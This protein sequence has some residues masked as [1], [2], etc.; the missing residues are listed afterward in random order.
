MNGLYQ[1]PSNLFFPGYAPVPSATYEPP[2]SL[3]NPLTSSSLFPCPDSSPHNGYFPQAKPKKG[4]ISNENTTYEGEI[5]DGKMHGK[6]ILTYADGVRYEGDFLNDKIHGSG[7][8]TWPNG[9]E[10]EGEF[11]N[12]LQ[13]GNGMQKFPDGRIYTG[14]F[15]KGTLTGVGTLLFSTGGFYSGHFVNDSYEGRGI[16]QDAGGDR[17]EGYFHEGSFHG[18]GTFTSHSESYTGQFQNGEYHG[19]G[20]LK[21]ANG[22]QIEGSFHDGEFG[23]TGKI[24]FPNG[25]V[26][27]GCIKDYKCEGQG[28]LTYATGHIYEGTF[29]AGYPNSKGTLTYQNHNR[30]TGEFLEGK[31]HGEGIL[32]FSNGKQYEGQFE[33]G[34]KTGEG[35]YTYKNG[36]KIGIFFIS[37]KLARINYPDGTKLIATVCDNGDL[38]PFKM[39]LNSDDKMKP[40]HKAYLEHLTCLSHHQYGNEDEAYA[41]FLE[42]L[43]A[44]GFISDHLSVEQIEHTFASIECLDW[45][46]KASEE[47]QAGIKLFIEIVTSRVTERESLLLKEA[48]KEFGCFIILMNDESIPLLKKKDALDLFNHI[49]FSCSDSIPERIKS[50]VQIL[51]SG[52]KFS[53]FFALQRN[54]IFQDCFV[55]YLRFRSNKK[56]APISEGYEI[57]A[58]PWLANM[59]SDRIHFYTSF[60]SHTDAYSTSEFDYIFLH[61][62]NPSAMEKLKDELILAV[63]SKIENDFIKPDIE[64]MTAYMAAML[65]PFKNKRT[66]SPKEFE[67]INETVFDVLAPALAGNVDEFD[68]RLELYFQQNPDGSY[69]LNGQIF[70]DLKYLVAKYL[71]HTGYYLTM[72]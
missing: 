7:L 26:Y 15:A 16:L 4:K 22:L 42:S 70:T 14:Q 34:M 69:S 37:D 48:W 66:L 56:M 3:F 71:E 43:R 27:V 40:K 68:N 32:V 11:K 46:L 17:Y 52:R 39:F 29:S 18:K 61:W 10:Y 8:K 25:D 53:D 41:P 47:S 45:F 2:S 33:N 21:K 58:Q 19:E 60:T 62:A 67:R 30:Y 49:Y 36:T 59:L 24:T 65:L 13:H 57:H 63:Y 23:D 72:S 5:L 44:Q 12:G 64:D 31:P 9:Y 51:I 50:I 38:I 54:M 1:T 6:G 28:V 20:I 35:I 55:E